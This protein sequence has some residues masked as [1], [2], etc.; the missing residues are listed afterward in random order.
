MLTTVFAAPS[1]DTWALKPSY[2]EGATE[3]LYDGPL[4]PKIAND[5]KRGPVALSED[6]FEIVTNVTLNEIRKIETFWF[7]ELPDHEVCPDEI[8]NENAE[9]LQYLFRLISMSYA[10]ESLK[11]MHVYLAKLSAAEKCTITSAELW[12]KCHPSDGEM[13][14]FIRRA[15]NDKQVDMVDRLSFSRSK[16]AL[17]DWW[18]RESAQMQSKDAGAVSSISTQFL[19][20]NLKA[21]TKATQA[22]AIQLLGEQCKKI[23]NDLR[24]ICNGHDYLYGMSSVKEARLLI[25]RSHAFAQVN[26]TGHGAGCLRRF[27]ELFQRLEKPVNYFSDLFPSVMSNLVREDAPY[28][29][30]KLFLL[31]SLQEFEEKGLTGLWYPEQA[32][33]TPTATPAAKKVVVVPKSTPTPTPVAVV[34]IRPTPTPTP[35]PKVPQFELA[36]RERIQYDSEKVPVNMALMR[37][38]YPFSDK[39]IVAISEP[40][41]NFQTR[42][43]IRDMKEL[44]HLGSKE[45]PVH[46]MF[47]KFL[48]DNDYHQGLFNFQ[49]EVGH[50]FWV[51]NDFEKG[52]V[53]QWIELTN[54]SSTQSRWQIYILKP[55]K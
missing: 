2:G 52:V 54:D 1:I 22:W 8:L 34:E 44:D 20:A 55:P 18:E 6:N 15:V 19:R 12:G 29:Q 5:R 21:N 53:P 32:T 24:M 17:G 46:L 47:L 41:K 35:V 11:D 7:F 43:A 16:K 36:V 50:K 13:S 26:K 23:K 42:K 33:P 51:I 28:L 3:G 49:A 45:E 14:K 25:E 39:M 48:I 31:G 38:D 40:I 9:F 30:G 37:A 10:Y 27:V 4:W